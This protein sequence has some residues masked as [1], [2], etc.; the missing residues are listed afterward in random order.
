MSVTFRTV[1]SYGAVFDSDQ[2]NAPDS[3]KSI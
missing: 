3:G 2:F 1:W